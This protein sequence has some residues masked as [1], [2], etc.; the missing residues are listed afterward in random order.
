METTSTIIVTQKTRNDGE[1]ELVFPQS[2][3]M[4]GT[5]QI[6]VQNLSL[7]YSWD[8][9]TA[10]FGN[11]TVQYRYNGTTYTVNIPDGY[12]N[13]TDIN[14]YIQLAMKTNGHYLVDAAGKDVYF[15]KLQL[16]Q[17]YYANTFTLT[18][19]PSALPV[20]W[21]NPAS[22]VL[23]GQTM[24][25]IM[26]QGMGKVLGLSPASYPS[27]AQSSVFQ[28]NSN[29]TPEITPVSFVYVHCDFVSDTRFNATTSDVISQI[30]VTNTSRGALFNLNPST[31]TFLPVTG[32]YYKKITIRLTDQ[33]NRPLVVRDTSAVLIA[34]LL[35]EMKNPQ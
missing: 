21:T 9:I 3:N 18:P 16:N 14:A 10:K 29:L 24:Q 2:L 33:E 26:P 25:L 28:F 6:G 31:I 34:L 30:I 8:N 35:K 17:V 7:W 20:G 1:F 15:F 19:V 11:N 32:G 22:M 13:F 12:Y 4:K 27:A 23:T 5:E